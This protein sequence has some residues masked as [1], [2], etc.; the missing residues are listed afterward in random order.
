MTSTTP[1]PSWSQRVDIFS[2]SLSSVNN[3]PF[4][5]LTHIHCNLECRQF[6]NFATVTT[7]LDT[8]LACRDRHNYTDFTE[9][10]KYPISLFGTDVCVAFSSWGTTLRVLI[11][12]SIVDNGRST[13]LHDYQPFCCDA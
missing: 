13:K 12:E 3:Q 7:T 1:V 5:I 11:L 4:Y 8:R 9:T 6:G 10:N 2:S